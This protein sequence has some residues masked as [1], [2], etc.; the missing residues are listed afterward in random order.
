MANRRYLEPAVKISKVDTAK[1]ELMAWAP[2][3]SNESDFAEFTQAVRDL[4]REVKNETELAL[5]RGK[6]EFLSEPYMLYRSLETAVGMERRPIHR[7]AAI[8]QI[9]AA[10]KQYLGLD[11]DSSPKKRKRRGLLPHV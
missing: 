3:D 2:D 10:L 11:F 6:V 4:M 1:L 5:M 8:S 9:K 7:A